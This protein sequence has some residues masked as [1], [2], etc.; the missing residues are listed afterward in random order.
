MSNVKNGDTIKIK[1]FGDKHL[2]GV[3]LRKKI[4]DW[5]KNRIVYFMDSES[6][7]KTE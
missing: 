5:F 4:S 1:M 3:N 7:S 6:N 2:L